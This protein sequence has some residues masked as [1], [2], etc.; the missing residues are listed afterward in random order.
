[1]KRT[2]DMTRGSILKLVVPLTIPLILTNL[3]QQLYMIVDASIVGRGIGVKALAAVGSAD[4][5]YWL[6]LWSVM[7]LTQGF[8]TFVSR[9][10]GKRD[11]RT[12]N[13]VIANAAILCFLIGGILTTVGCLAARPILTLLKTPDDIIG[14]A[15]VYLT[16]MIGGTLVVTAY[17]MSASILRAFGNGKTPLM[18]MVIAALTNIGLDFLFVLVFHW[19][20]FGAA[21]ASISA[22]L[23]SFLYCL[24]QIRRIEQVRICREDW[25]FDT[26]LCSDML[27]FSL[28]IA[29]QF[30]IIA[31]SGIVLQSTINA[32]GSLFV[33]GFTAT[34]KLYGILESTAISIGQ[35]FA[36]FY[37]QNYGAGHYGR[38]KEGVVRGLILSTLT[39]IIVSAI[40]IPGG[41][42]FLQAFV[43]RNAENGMEILEIAYHYLFIMASC[44]II[45]YPIHIY[46]NA[47]QSIGNSFWT[48]VSGFAESAMRILF[49]KMVVQ[50]AGTEAVFYAEPAAWM[51]AL[52]FSLLPYYYY[53]RKLLTHHVRRGAS[54]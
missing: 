48:M 10:F 6:I 14:D 53:E 16:T 44:L 8:A 45:I 24:G 26:M 41:R 18:A 30:I 27:K 36:T 28:P 19:G 23:L 35:A 42:T 9:Y 32:H 15:A 20:V 1:M 38:V 21:I 31:L 34:N 50:W 4:W 5:S 54:T 22:Q 51:G 39:T 47:L 3:G 37:S 40:V 7:G 33:A 13:R 12:M 25:R 2:T 43:D 46:R 17:N 52:L 11:F 29:F 49:A